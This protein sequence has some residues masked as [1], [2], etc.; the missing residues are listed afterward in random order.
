MKKFSIAMAIATVILFITGCEESSNWYPIE[1]GFINLKQAQNITT[2]AT[3]E[4]MYD[5]YDNRVAMSKK[6]ITE[7]NINEAIKELKKSSK[8][9]KIMQCK[10]FIEIDGFKIELAKLEGELTLDNIENM[11]ES[12]LD[13]VEDLED[14]LD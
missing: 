11:L 8:T 3:L 9:I 13:A 2:E 1:G 10:A 14:R 6:A 5:D 4:V 12:W 7:D